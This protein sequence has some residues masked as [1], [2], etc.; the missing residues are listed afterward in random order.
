CLPPPVPLVGRA[1]DPGVR[2][3]DRDLLADDRE[4]AGRNRLS[5][6]ERAR[7]PSASRSPMPMPSLSESSAPSMVA[8]K[9]VPP[10]APSVTPP[11]EPPIM[12]LGTISTCPAWIASAKRPI[13]SCTRRYFAPPYASTCALIATPFASPTACSLVASAAPVTCVWCAFA[14]AVYLIASA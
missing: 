8:K 12:I 4:A 3:R 11:P 9:F 5:Y 10:P 2:R 7:P 14:S 13:T 6:F 1:R